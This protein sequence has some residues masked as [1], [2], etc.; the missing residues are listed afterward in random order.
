MLLSGT[1][2]HIRPSRAARAI[3]LTS[4]TGAVAVAVPL[5]AAGSTSATTAS[6]W[7]A[8]AQCESGGNWA[9]STGNGYYGGLQFSAS[10]W[11][12]Y[13]GTRYAATADRATKAQQIQIAE[14]VLAGQGQ[15]AWPMCGKGLSKATYS[16][17]A[18]SSVQPGQGTGPRSTGEHTSRSAERPV[19]SQNTETVGSA[20]GEGFVRGDGEYTVVKGDTLSKIAA[21]NR[22]D[23]GWRKL[24]QLNRDIVATANL[25]YP[26]QQLR[27]T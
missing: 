21:M 25:I 15:G 17:P 22:I 16:S 1:R 7:E 19:V 8:V 18:D 20:I 4:V 10:T 14:K 24:F 26:G 9:I 5:V 11:A 23:G 6:E 13:G 27:L 2:K 3:A 12:A